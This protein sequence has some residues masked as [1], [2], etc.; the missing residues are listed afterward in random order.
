[1]LATTIQTAK[2]VLYIYFLVLLYPIATCLI[3]VSPME[4]KHEWAKLTG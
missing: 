4:M 1:M 2:A 3:E